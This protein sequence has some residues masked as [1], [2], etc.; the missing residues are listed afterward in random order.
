[1]RRVLF[2]DDEPHILEGIQ[3][4]LRSYRHVWDMEFVNSGDAALRAMETQPFDVVVT[5][6][7]MPGMDGAALLKEVKARFPRAVRIIL[8]GY[9][10]LEAAMQSVWVSH[11]YLPKPCEA[12]KLKSVVDRACNLEMF[13]QDP[14]LQATLGELGE[15]PVLPRM[16]RALVEALAK[17][18]VDLKRVGMIVERDQAIAA[19]ILQIANSSCFGMRREITSIEQATNDLGALTIQGLV[20]SG[21]VFREFEN[22]D[23]VES[24]FLEREQKHSLLTASIARRLLPGKRSADKA[25]LVG[26]LLDI[27]VLVIAASLPERLAVLLEAGAGI[28]EPFHEVEERVF[29]VSHA[30]IGAYLLGLWGL[31]YPIVEAIAHHHHPSRVKEESEFG[32]LAAVHV[33][34]TLAHELGSCAA[35]TPPL[36]EELLRG[37]GVAERIPEWRALAVEEAENELVVA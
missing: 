2:V 18:E 23:S 5:D 14:I 20:L 3:R 6:M 7:R 9:G 37:L 13:L 33:A 31:P 10:D 35:I 21:E 34:D 17:P 12:D 22:S 25:F 30:G 11:Q 4:M 36:D 19:K 16:Y 26:A 24:L 15:L 28:T 8:S 1:M 27:G 32:V 29:G